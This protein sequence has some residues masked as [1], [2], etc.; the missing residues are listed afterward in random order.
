MVKL[1]LQIERHKIQRPVYLS[2]D[3]FKRMQ[4]E[5][6]RRN[7][8][9]KKWTQHLA[10]VRDAIENQYNIDR[11]WEEGDDASKDLTQ[12]DGGERRPDYDRNKSR[13]EGQ[14]G[15]DGS[16]DDEYEEDDGEEDEGLGFGGDGDDYGDDYGAGDQEFDDAG[17]NM[18]KVN[19]GTGDPTGTFSIFI[20][21]LFREAEYAE[22]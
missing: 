19:N 12:V 8:S 16:G 15:G 5:E 9:D 10:E 11:S 18:L 2:D 4:E 20:L 14:G 13:F 17:D 7:E 3:R 22:Q 1:K 6:K 21:H